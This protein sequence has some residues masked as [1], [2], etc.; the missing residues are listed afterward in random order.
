MLRKDRQEERHRTMYG[1]NEIDDFGKR[2][3]LICH[4]RII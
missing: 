4:R 2:D 1:K 3:I